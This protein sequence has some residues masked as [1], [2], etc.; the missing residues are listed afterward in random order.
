MKKPKKAKRYCP[1][2]KKHTEQ[3]V[4]ITKQGGRSSAHPL[5][6]W[7]P[8]RVRRRGL[9]RGCGNHGKFSKPA[10]KDWK[11]KTKTTKKAVIMYT[12]MQCSKSSLAQRGMRTGRVLIEDK[13]SKAAKANKTLAGIKKE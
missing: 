9:N 5:S 11:R 8:S 3:K 10:I 13:E 7:G 4:A 2:C 1:F 6:K 12:C